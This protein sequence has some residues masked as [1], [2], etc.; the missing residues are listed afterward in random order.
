MTETPGIQEKHPLHYIDCVIALENG[1][2]RGL[3]LKEIIQQE[4]MNRVV[5]YGM[6]LQETSQK[7]RELV[8]KIDDA[9]VQK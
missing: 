9:N 6:N 3:T 7:L 5:S 2:Q 8:Q 4:L 1:T